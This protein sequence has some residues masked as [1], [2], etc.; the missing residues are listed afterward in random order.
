MPRPREEE[1]VIFVRCADPRKMMSFIDC[2]RLS[3]TPI[4]NDPSLAASITSQSPSNPRNRVLLVCWCQSRRRLAASSIRQCNNGI[5]T[6][7]ARIRLRPTCRQPQTALSAHPRPSHEQSCSFRHYSSRLEVCP[8]RPSY[9]D[10]PPQCPAQCRCRQRH[11]PAS[12]YASHQHRVRR[13]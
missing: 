8:R 13:C 12:E 9:K 1:H 5:A 11:G 6:P 7:S 2:R 10:G 3:Y 4:A